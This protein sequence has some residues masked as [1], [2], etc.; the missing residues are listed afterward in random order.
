MNTRRLVTDAVLIAL[1]VV[2]NFYTIRL[3]WLNISLAAFPILVAA[4][5]YGWADGLIV[6]AMSGFISQLLTYGLSVT[7]IM[8][9]LPT[10]V[11]GL[12]VGLYAT[13]RGFDLNRKQIGFIVLVRCLVVTLLNTA[14]LYADSL[15]YH[16]PVALTLG[17]IAL[18]L[19]SSVVMA[20]VFTI[21]T[22]KAIQLL[23]AAGSKAA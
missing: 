17:T 19:V 15:I 3:G 4:L 9:M 10:L 11:R 8:W 12:M 6:G 2:L 5:L 21:I 23:R 7:T 16:Y 20:V 14:A 22:P 1:Y 13:K 18:R